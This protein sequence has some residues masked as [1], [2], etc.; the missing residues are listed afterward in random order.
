M[1][2]LRSLFLL[3]EILS[4]SYN[5]WSQENRFTISGGYTFANIE[6][7]DANANGWRIN[8]LYE[9]NP[10]EGKIAHGFS[11]GYIGLST[12]VDNV[13]SVDYKTSSWPI[14]Y[15]PKFM[16]GE[17]SFNAFVKGA[18]GMHFSSHKRTGGISEVKTND[19]GFYGGLGAGIMKDF[20]E[21]VFLNL[22]YEWAYLGNS[23]YKDGFMNSI[24][25]GLG[26]KF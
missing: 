21:T 7:V 10:N 18:L 23:Y 25:L 4:I 13:Q 9:F 11:F 5:S 2:T 1:K 6:D 14:Y 8:G 16:F 22:E 3:L 20:N 15:A 17:D 12:T 24:L 19:T 26:F